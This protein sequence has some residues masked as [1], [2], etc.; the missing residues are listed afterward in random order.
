M[1]HKQ[2]NSDKTTTTGKYLW[3]GTC[4]YFTLFCVILLILAFFNV[5][6]SSVPPIRFLLLLPMA[7]TVASAN[8]IFSLTDW[9]AGVRHVL[10]MILCLLGFYLFVCLPV[11]ISSGGSTF[12]MFVLAILL[13]AIGLAVYLIVGHARKN[14]KTES[15]PYES[16]FTKS[17]K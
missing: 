4:R 11:Q 8:A 5:F 14:K 7:A 1:A 12:V 6:G 2:L 15:V 10:H 9:S 3:N 16:Q 17:K 13:Y